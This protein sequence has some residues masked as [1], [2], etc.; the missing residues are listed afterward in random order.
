M[1]SKAAWRS[2]TSSL[3][4]SEFIRHVTADPDATPVE[5]ELAM[6]LDR[7]LYSTDPTT[8]S[9]LEAAGQMRLFS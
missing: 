8:P 7:M 6:R 3:T 2:F 5:R 4:D 1:T 9:A